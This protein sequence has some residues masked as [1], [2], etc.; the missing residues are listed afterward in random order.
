MN[1]SDIEK[2]KLLSNSPS[3]VFYI[4]RSKLR[5]VVEI[6]HKDPYI[7]C[8]LLSDGG[9]LLNYK[10]RKCRRVIAKMYYNL[11]GSDNREITNIEIYEKC[12]F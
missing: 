5:S 7:I 8:E 9:F 6:N 11:V 10:C 1:I 4:V 12:L 2:L 3:D